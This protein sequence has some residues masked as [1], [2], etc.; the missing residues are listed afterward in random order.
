MRHNFLVT[1][2][3][4]DTQRSQSLSCLQQQRTSRRVDCTCESRH[5]SAFSVLTENIDYGATS[6]ISVHFSSPMT[7]SPL[8]IPLS[9]SEPFTDY[10]RWRMV[11]DEDGRH[12]WTYLRTDEECANWPQ[13]PLDKFW[14]GLPTVCRRSSAHPRNQLNL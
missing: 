1:Q 11:V 10:S 5:Q 6:V 2:H 3:L 9:S 13:K 12:S 14:I 8:E 4:A 7:F